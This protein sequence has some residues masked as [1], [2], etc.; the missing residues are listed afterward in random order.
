MPGIGAI[1]LAAGASQR[2]GPDNKLLASIGGEPLVRRVVQALMRGD[3]PDIV[4]VTGHERPLVEAAL[5]ALPIR[6][7]HNEN[8]A[9]GMASSIVSGVSALPAAIDGAFIVPGDM[10]FLTAK[11]I[12]RLTEVFDERHRA[13]IVYPATSGGEQRNPVLWP[14]RFF[15]DLAA[16]SGPQ[17]AKQLLAALGEECI[18]VAADDHVFADIDTEADLA[19]ARAQLEK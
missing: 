12:E 2:F 9:S 3:I 6:F 17:G 10:P 11:V 8:W 14:R 15:G 5:D 19:A 13:S 7:A 1:V 18:A 16:L 4:V